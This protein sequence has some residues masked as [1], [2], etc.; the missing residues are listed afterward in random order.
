VPS[1]ICKINF[2]LKQTLMLP[3]PNKW[4]KKLKKKEFFY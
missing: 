4:K 2:K 1:F 3:L